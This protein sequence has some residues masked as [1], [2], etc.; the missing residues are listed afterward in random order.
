MP[1]HPQR[2]Q[3]LL[4]LETLLDTDTDPQ[5]LQNKKI[6]AVVSTGAILKRKPE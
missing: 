5:K 3:K 2:D 1:H 6:S 4:Q